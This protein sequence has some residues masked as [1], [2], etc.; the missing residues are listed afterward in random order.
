MQNN[1]L[2]L[3]PYLKKN[4]NEIY[5]ER[6]KFIYEYSSIRGNFKFICPKFLLAKP[7]NYPILQ[8]LFNETTRCHIT[9]G[10]LLLQSF[11]IQARRIFPRKTGKYKNGTGIG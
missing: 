10:N 11:W 1:L 6:S 3:I 2:E 4:C 5:G 8:P 9:F 7:E